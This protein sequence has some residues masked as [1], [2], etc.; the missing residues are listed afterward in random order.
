MSTIRQNSIQQHMRRLEWQMNVNLQ[1]TDIAK[2]Q[3]NVGLVKC[4]VDEHTRLINEYKSW[5]PYLPPTQQNQTSVFEIQN[6][7]NTTTQSNIYWKTKHKY[8]M[9]I[10]KKQKKY[11]YYKYES[12]LDTIL[13]R[14][15]IVYGYIRRYKQFYPKELIQIIYNFYFIK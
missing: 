1:Q 2:A 13:K 5:I 8:S 4:Y 7:I 6:N 3:N 12:S 9:N 14:P 15:L 10:I 11:K